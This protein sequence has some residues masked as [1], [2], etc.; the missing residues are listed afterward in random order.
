MKS[1]KV[2]AIIPAR[3][4]SKGIPNKNIRLLRGKPLIQHA[5]DYAKASALIDKIIVT[6]DSDKII[7]AS[8]N[9]G[10]D[11]VKRPISIAGDK[12]LVIDAIRHA[13]DE[14]EIHHNF[15]P[16]IIILLECTSPIKNIDEIN[17]AIE[18][19]VKEDFDSVATFKETEISPNRI[20]RIQ[21]E[22]VTPFIKEAKPFL[23]RQ[24]QPKAYKLT[25]QLYAVK[26]KKLKENLENPSL[27]V[28]KVYP[29]ITITEVIDIDN[30]IDFL[31]AEEILK[32]LEK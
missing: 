22:L 14:C 1:K 12:A 31:V 23:P 30:E 2:L 7:E 5:I 20:W 11:V 8:L 26:V 17:K 9:L 28:G 16:E 32:Y 18:I 6:T 29:L 25:G 4:G 3:G 13:I 21:D 19:L 24:S 15:Y 10:V 27:L